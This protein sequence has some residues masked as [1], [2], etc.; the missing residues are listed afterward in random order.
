MKD[1][2]YILTMLA[3]ALFCTSCF[4]VEEDIIPES[5]GA[6]T[7]SVFVEVDFGNLI[8]EDLVGFGWNV[9]PT[10]IPTSNATYLAD[11][12]KYFLEA[13]NSWIRLCTQDYGWERDS[14]G[15]NDDDDP[16]T[17]PDNWKGFRWCEGDDLSDNMGAGFYHLMDLC[18]ANDIEVE[19][20]HWN[21]EHE[22]TWLDHDRDADGYITEE[23]MLENAA[24]FGEYLGALIYYLK[25]TANNGGPYNCVKYYALWNEP[26][27]M[28]KDDFI[29]WDHPGYH[30][31]LF[32]KVKAQLEY[33]DKLKG[34][35]VA[36]E[37]MGIGLEG[38]T[39]Y[40]NSTYG[41]TGTWYG[42]IGEGVLTYDVAH[43]GLA[44][45]LNYNWPNADDE[46]DFISIHHYNSH[47]DYAI[48]NESLQRTIGNSFLPYFVENALEQVATF[49]SDGKKE[50]IL[51]NELGSHRIC[52]DNEHFPM[53]DHMFLS[54]EGFL[55]SINAGVAGGSIWCYNQHMFYNAV[56]YPG[57][58]Y[59]DYIEGYDVEITEENYYLYQLFCKSVKRG[60]NVYSATCE[61]G[62]DDSADSDQEFESVEAQRVWASAVITEGKK[63]IIIVND[64]FNEKYISITAAGMGDAV[65]KEVVSANNYKNGISTTESFKT[66]S[67]NQIVDE[68]A[69]RS[70]TVYSEQ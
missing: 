1:I 53:F 65:T 27:G 34:T 47:F 11:W 46:C 38:G 42:M 5:G 52:S 24:E 62:D 59:D 25:T 7:Y 30:N 61:G 29:S 48:N 13:N 17:D 21:T 31:L 36:S 37:M 63:K 40:R 33:Y 43:G 60:S 4:D 51:I 44:G 18:E 35:D 10:L 58:W 26:A 32:T 57:V 15:G 28:E 64:S 20:N 3:C 2:K 70:I 23:E 19:I 12:D 39:Q 56:I 8:N 54:V 14:K 9:H 50:R 16:L 45:E 41:G 68:L 49:D 66:R 55:R 67:S 6:T 22:A 69:A